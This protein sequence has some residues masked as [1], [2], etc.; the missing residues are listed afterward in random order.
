VLEEAE[1]T[2]IIA[3]DALVKQNINRGTF[4]WVLAVADGGT[5]LLRNLF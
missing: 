5:I 1:K 4:A 2:P 3:S